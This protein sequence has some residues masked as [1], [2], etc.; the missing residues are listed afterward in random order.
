MHKQLQE[1]E[2]FAVESTRQRVRDNRV[3]TRAQTDNS[4]LHLHA[5]YSFSGIGYAFQFEIPL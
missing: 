2:R 1:T 5:A 3:C 4:F